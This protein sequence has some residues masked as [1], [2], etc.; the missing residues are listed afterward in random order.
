MSHKTKQQGFTLVE[1]MLAMV[2]VA[3]ILVF[4]SLTL[5]QMFRTYDKGSSMKQVNQAGRSVIEEISQAVRSQ[6]P[7]NI[8][9]GA[10]GNGVLCIDRVMYVWNPLY[11]TAG[12]Q[13]T[14]HRAVIGNTTTGGMMARKV[15]SGATT[16]PTNLV[17]ALNTSITPVSQETQLLSNQTRVLRASAQP[18]PDT[19]LVKLNFVIGTYSRSEMPAGSTHYL[20]AT[21][22]GGNFSCLPGSDGTYCAFAEFNTV[23]YLSKDQ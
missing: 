21:Q 15:L 22:S 7:A 1:L 11:N 10:V 2:F 16:C 13:V 4:I 12:V 20:T 5:V 19:H 23:V 3:F 14:D 18:L 9:T 8:K 17:D 6:L